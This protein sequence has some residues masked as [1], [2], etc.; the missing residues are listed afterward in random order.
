M[1]PRA[2][3]KSAELSSAN[4]TRLR[5]RCL[6]FG[7]TQVAVSDRLTLRPLIGGLI[8][9]GAPSHPPARA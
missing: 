2:V 1:K 5:N 3:S 7:N 8:S 6:M 4:A 9:S